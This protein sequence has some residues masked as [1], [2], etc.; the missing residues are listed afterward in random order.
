MG[1]ILQKNRSRKE[2]LFLLFISILVCPFISFAEIREDSVEITPF[3]HFGLYINNISKNSDTKNIYT[4]RLGYNITKNIG[5]EVAGDAIE[6]TTK[7]LHTNMLYHFKTERAFNPFI[8][9]GLG[10][11]NSELDGNNS[12][13]FMGNFGL[14]FKY[15]FTKNFA[16]RADLS[17]IIAD[18]YDVALT[19]GLFFL[20]YVEE[21]KPPKMPIAPRPE[22]EMKM[23]PEPVVEIA[24]P[25]PPPPPAPEPKVEIAKPAPP[26]PP[27]PEPKVEIAKPAPPPPPAPEP[28]IT[29]IKIILEDVNFDFE[30]SILTP[31]A[32]EIL[33]KNIKVLKENPGIKVEIEGHTCAHGSDAYNMALGERRAKEVKEYLITEGIAAERLTT[34]S[35]G[36]SR[37]LMPEIP[38]PH[39]KYSAEAKANRRVHFNIISY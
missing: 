22:P 12:S 5:I 30:K 24:K 13:N 8:T 4:L 34:I 6:A 2:V 19:A 29:P 33:N 14:G 28:V 32:K 35:Y 20:F 16:M 11:L 10:I 7:M 21:M 38:T 15:F 17:N 26:P 27:A 39:N 37:L 1:K 9:G 23:P 18:K 25:A 3:P 36:E 31:V